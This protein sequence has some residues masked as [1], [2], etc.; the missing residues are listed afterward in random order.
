[1][2]AYTTAH[3]AYEAADDA[4]HALVRNPRT[5]HAYHAHMLPLAVACRDASTTE[6]DRCR[7]GIRVF[8]HQAACRERAVPVKATRGANT[9]MRL[10]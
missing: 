5:G 10:F 6:H 2:D 8:G 7:W 4:R 3:E 9:Q 1:M